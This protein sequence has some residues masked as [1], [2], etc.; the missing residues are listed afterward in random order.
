M[1][2]M[3]SGGVAC[4][5][6]VWCHFVPAVAGLSS[7]SQSA[8][9]VA[10]LSHLQATFTLHDGPPYANGDLHIGHALNKILKVHWPAVCYG[11]IARPP[12]L[13]PRVLLS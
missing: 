3:L 13:T 10:T 4:S 1:L 11:G 7:G 8:T 5:L 2:G 6:V 12:V 9:V